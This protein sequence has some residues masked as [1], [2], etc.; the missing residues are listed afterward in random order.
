MNHSAVG[1]AGRPQNFKSSLVLL[2]VLAIGSGCGDHG[3]EPKVSPASYLAGSIITSSKDSLVADGT[4]TATITVTLRDSLGK[5]ARKSV[6]LVVVQ[7]DAGSVGSV[8]D[9]D[10]GTYVATFTSP[11][12]IGTATIVARLNGAL[13][14]KSASVKLVAGPVD[15]QRSTLESSATSVFADG[16]DV[17]R[18]YVNTRDANGNPTD[19]G[20][21]RVTIATTLGTLGTMTQESAGRYYNTLKS[22]TKGAAVVTAKIDDRPVAASITVSFVGGFWVK[23]TSMTEER[24]VFAIGVYDGIL[25][26]VGGGGWTTDSYSA[27]VNAYDP[28]TNRWTTRAPMPTPRGELAAGVIN[29]VL[30]AVGGYKSTDLS[31]VEA[32]DIAANRWSSRAP[33]PTAREG[34][35][36]AVVNGILYAIGGN[37]RGSSSSTSS[38]S[39]A[40]LAGASPTLRFNLQSADHALGTVEAYDPATD[41]WTVKASM[42]TPRSMLG[43]GVVNGI[44]YAVGGASGA[45]QYRIVEAYNPA[46][47]SWTK[48]SDMPSHTP[49]G[50]SYGRAALSVGVVNDMLYAVGGFFV[51]QETDMVDVYDPSRDLWAPAQH[52]PTMRQSLGIGVI[53]GVLYAVGGACYDDTFNL[54]EALVP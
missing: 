48:K 5:A 25:Y 41:S 23:K 52:M 29:G 7:T 28:A 19:S 40:L 30:Y 24:Q 38:S 50:M 12:L 49:S 27:D 35:A 26:T 39:A 8:V 33:M 31:T 47:D 46:T 34:L 42:P 22:D 44:I 9:H 3:T 53:D 15:L 14:A 45:Q 20:V 1:R 10:D 43:V 6:G 18:V 16:I 17:S 13:L 4:T 11:R 32:Y 51:Y 36:V 2:T 37:V 54:V 21:G